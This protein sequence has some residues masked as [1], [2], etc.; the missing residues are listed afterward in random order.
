MPDKFMD[1]TE[2]KD[3]NL[4]KDVRRPYNDGFN[5]FLDIKMTK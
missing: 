3:Y 1:I 4:H 2:R 5:Y